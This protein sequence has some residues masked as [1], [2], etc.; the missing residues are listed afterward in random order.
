MSHFSHI[1][2]IMIAK[3]PI[4]VVI[5]AVHETL[6]GFDYV[7]G[8]G[9]DYMSFHDIETNEEFDEECRDLGTAEEAN[10]ALKDLRNHRTGGLVKYAMP[11]IEFNKE[12]FPIGHG[13]S[14][15]YCSYDDL[16]IEAL[17]CWTRED[18]Y[19]MEKEFLDATYAAIAKKVNCLDVFHGV[20]YDSDDSFDENR[21]IEHF[22]EGNPEVK[23]RYNFPAE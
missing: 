15:S 14:I 4:A 16:T 3:S 22:F 8:F 18:V 7:L 13:F 10:E 2:V 9:G 11:P 17:I 19:E 12:G 23:Y 21:I 1:A 6:L 5:D 20:D